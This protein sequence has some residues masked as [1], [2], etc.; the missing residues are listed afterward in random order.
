MHYVDGQMTYDNPKNCSFLY[1]KVT[2]PSGE[3]ERKDLETDIHNTLFLQLI[4]I[5]FKIYL[6]LLIHKNT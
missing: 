2:K 3:D 6:W 5:L 1:T 4:F